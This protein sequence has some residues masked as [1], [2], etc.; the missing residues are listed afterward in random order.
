MSTFALWEFFLINM[1]AAII[2]VALCNSKIWGMAFPYPFT[3][4]GPRLSSVSVGYT[5]GL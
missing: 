5:L 3:L 2:I 4:V 1:S